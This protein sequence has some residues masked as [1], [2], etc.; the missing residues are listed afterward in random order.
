MSRDNRIDYLLL[1]TRLHNSL[2]ESPKA[3]P[4]TGN[5]FLIKY[6]SLY[7]LTDGTNNSQHIS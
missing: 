4:D 2:A 6:P 5:A 3:L 1:F 7:L